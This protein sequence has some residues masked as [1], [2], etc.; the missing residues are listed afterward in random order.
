M[1]R[2]Y[3]S[4]I[5]LLLWSTNAFSGIFPGV[6]KTG[7]GQSMEII[8][9]AKDLLFD[10]EYKD[11]A[12]LL[13]N[14]DTLHLSGQEKVLYDLTRSF[15]DYQ[16]GDYKAAIRRLERSMTY[17]RIARETEAEIN[18]VWGFILE[19]A[20]VKTEASNYYHKAMEYYMKEADPDRYLYAVLG[21]ARTSGNPVVYLTDAAAFLED[22]PEP[23]FRFL[24]Y[25]A[26]A[27]CEKNKKL[28]HALFKKAL[29]LLDQLSDPLKKLNLYNS[30]VLS[31]L[32]LDDSDSAGF[33]LGKIH[34]QLNVTEI[35]GER[36]FFYHLIKG[37]YHTEKDELPEALCEIE[38]AEQ[39][40]AGK[41]GQL[42]QVYRRKYDIEMKKA[43]YQ[44]ANK[45]LLNHLKYE[46]QELAKRQEIQTSLLNIRYEL[47]KRKLEIAKIRSSRLLILL[48]LFATVVAFIMVF[49]VYKNRKIR[50]IKALNEKLCAGSA[51]KE[52]LLQKFIMTSE[53]LK[54]SIC[55][56]W[57]KPVNGNYEQRIGRKENAAA[58]WETFISLFRAKNPFFE[59]RLRK[60]HP[61]LSPVDTRYCI[62]CY[63]LLTNQQV[64]D[65][66]EVTPDAV[67]KARRKLKNSFDL[68]TTNE[69][70]VYLHKL[71]ADKSLWVQREV[72]G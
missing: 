61:E 16:L 68:Q 65:L 62:C 63:N 30:L 56:N 52:A 13:Q 45:Y 24:Y 41:A 28:K 44:A 18:L 34:E 11:A 39:T 2:L 40:C 36:L 27:Y 51:E 22:H 21:L 60:A 25:M 6:Q 38:L 49:L 57:E 66:L 32:S 54:E 70:Q 15:L 3:V 26:A 10:N 35:S 53:R 1:K 23:K 5:L 17:P 29:P 55:S 47:N 43:D 7:P 42:S 64:A 48:F 33:Y 46:R 37:M 69:L 58:S 4:I 12:P 14:V 31:S 9:M 19:E 71:Y 59:E 20:L 8:S 67:K 50:Q 72:K